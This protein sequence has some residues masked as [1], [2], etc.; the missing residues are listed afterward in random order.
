MWFVPNRSWETEIVPYRSCAIMYP[1]DDRWALWDLHDRRA[2]WFLCFL[3]FSS[4]QLKSDKSSV[5]VGYVWAIFLNFVGLFQRMKILLWAFF[6]G[7]KFCNVFIKGCGLKKQTCFFFFSHL[8]Q[9][10]FN[11]FWGSKKTYEIK[12]SNISYRICIYRLYPQIL[13]NPQ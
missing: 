10:C 5:F 6:K 4:F 9:G 1:I 12:L 2:L 8:F 3:S 13:V 11:L 7:W